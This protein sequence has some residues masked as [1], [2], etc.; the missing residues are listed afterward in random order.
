M[1]Y[2]DGHL[3]DVL[4]PPPVTLNGQPAEGS[5]AIYS[6]HLPIELQVA[7][8]VISQRQEHWRRVGYAE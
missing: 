2:D 3:P 8:W 7:I 6:I 5:K 1:T 4:A